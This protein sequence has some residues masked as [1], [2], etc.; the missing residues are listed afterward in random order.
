[1]GEYETNAEGIIFLDKLN[2]GWLKIVETRSPEG[3]LPD[4]TPKDVEIT[5][6]QF[7]RLVFENRQMSG[8]R[9]IKLDSVTK[10]G[11]YNVEFMVF[12]SGGKAIGTYYTDNRGIIDSFGELPA[13]RLTIRE[14]RPANGYYRDDVPRTIEIRAGKYTEVIWENTPQMAQI[15]ILKLSGDDNEVNGLPQGTPLAGAVFEAYE[16]KSG[17]VVDRFVS[18]ADGRA[19]SRPL[20]LGRYIVREVQAPQ[21]YKLSAQALDIDLEFATQIVKTEFLNYAANTGVHIRKTGVVECMPGDIISYDIRAVRNTSTVSL[22]DFYWRDIL[23][24]DAV[25]LTRIVTGTYNQSLKYKVMITTN[26][27]DTRVIADNLCTTQ[28]NVI[29]CSNASLGLWNDEYVTSVTFLFGTVKAGFSQVEQPRIF[30]RALTTLPNQYQF[31]NKADV[32]GK[33]G[34]EWVVGNSTWLTTIY[35]KPE[36]LPRTGH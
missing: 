2:P 16:Y 31:A 35:R 26:K 20:P 3:Y 25:R 32:G 4:D 24:V 17:N 13:G 6:N 28:N 19:V 22:T 10:K 8:L 12:D 15:Q 14:T 36:K 5:N 11:I 23:P 7:L 29:D 33:Y 1:L 18:G 9:L 27:G 21:W 30:V 34:N